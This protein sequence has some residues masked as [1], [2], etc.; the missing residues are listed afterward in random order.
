MQ[1][2]YECVIIHKHGSLVKRSRRRPLTAKTR[3]RF[4]YELLTEFDYINRTAQPEKHPSNLG[5]FFFLEI[6][7][8]KKGLQ[9]Q[10]FGV[11]VIETI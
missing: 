9:F 10:R 7:F 2:T 11:K 8:T 4:P 3:V 6:D 5:C 1:N